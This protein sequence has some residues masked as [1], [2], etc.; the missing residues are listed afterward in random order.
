[1]NDVNFTQRA[2]TALRLAQE[3]A[4]ELGHGYVGTEHLLLGLLR[5]GGGVAARVLQSA[6]LEAETIR[7]AILR[8]VGSGIPGALPSQGLTP[9]FRHIIELALA[10]AGRL[11][12]DYVGTEHLLLGLLQEG[13]GVAIRVLSACGQDPR[14]LAGDLSAAMG[15]ELPPPF[16]S[17]GKA[18][19][20]PD[21]TGAGDSKLLEQ[22]S[23]DLTRMAA[24]GLLDP[25][26]GREGEIDRVIQILSRRRK[27]N[28][29]LIGEPGVGKTAVAE[30]LA[31]RLAAG[32][33]PDE[34]RSKRLLALDLSSMVAG[35]KYRGEFEERVK[36][37]LGEVVRLGNIIL[38]I[39]ELHTIVGAG[40]AEGAIDAANIIKPALGRGEIQV[41]GA[42][43]TSEYRRYIEKD[44]ALERR[45]QP[46][47]VSEPDEATARSI[48]LGIR[49]RYE[50]HHK[51]RISD[52]ALDA[53]LSLSIRYLADRRL[54]DK[55]IDLMDE[56]A[57][58]VRLERLSAPA[59]LRE[60]EE[61]V[62][63]ARREKEEAIR[64]QDFEK[65]A[66]L[67]DA[68]SDFRRELDRE[69]TLWHSGQNVG[70]VTAEDV[71][72]VVSRWTGVPVTSLTQS[73]K[74]RLLALERELHRRVI[75]QDEAV[76]A[77]ARAVRRG[78]VGLKE[79]GR[80][81]GVFL[82]LGPTGVGKTELCKA[83]AA[84]LFGSEEALL[85]FD[86]SE[87]MER[88]TVSRLIGSP[89]GYIGHDEGGQLT[90]AVRRRPYSVLLFDEL[91]KAHEDVWG[92]LLQIT[93]DGVVTD[94]QGRKADFR[95]T[96]IVMTSNVGAAR[97]TAKGGKLGFQSALS[98]G[99][100]RPLTELKEAV[101]GDLKR[102]FRPEFL[103]RLDDTIVFR[104]LEREQIR[105]I[106][107]RMLDGV[108][109]RL[110]RLGVSLHVEED[111]L[112]Q[113]AREGFAPDY[114]A[115]PLRRAIRARVEDP[116]A[117][118]LLSGALQAGGAVR[119]VLR[120]GALALEPQ[121]PA[122]NERSLE[123]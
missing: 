61:R 90:E 92:L 106:A 96:V 39:D 108:G 47:T 80:P 67:R 65:A 91:E 50:A 23:R 32:E 76:Q 112:E 53:A 86:M 26:V 60:L 107:R 27:N 121:S 69:R 52:E 63:Q 62:A 48:L 59:D 94:T 43:T 35:T 3:S 70:E 120:E 83:L 66:M 16:R 56:A 85:R 87:Y 81:I 74:D 117:E 44:A 37:L 123:P 34:L 58:L 119:L 30:G 12:Q 45:F 17:G 4:A 22:F 6:G 2:Q 42:T 75:G 29:A 71:A 11:G 15:G 20:E 88:H 73:E 103:N 84:A 118:A 82:F 72:Q 64:S 77:V 51:L 25:V 111:A 89:P 102:V 31:R 10:H 97:I 41:I 115:R 19:S 36:Q 113:L 114:G 78:R 68:E 28:P 110:V 49:G 98:S 54:P 57:A 122:T 9:R 8:A 14:R 7:T 109:E 18:K 105:T 40:S 38:F 95:N 46:V 79:P 100:T 1:M 55:A 116:A 99:E 104:Q 5:E 93:E 21:Y 33:V 13:E 24:S 101:M